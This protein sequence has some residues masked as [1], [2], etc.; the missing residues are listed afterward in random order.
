MKKSTLMIIAAIAVLGMWAISSYN[1]LVD[2]DEEVK[3][4]WADVEA[5]YQRRMDLV[6]QAVSIVKSSAKFEK[7]TLTE[8]IEARSKATSITLNVDSL[9]EESMRKFQEAQS[10]L[11]GSLSRLMAVSEA[12]PEL[13][14]MEGFLQLQSQVEGTEN[15]INEVRKK[16]NATVKPYNV[17]VRQFPGSIFAAIFGFKTKAEFQADPEAKNAPKIDMDI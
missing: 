1:G 10:Q 9:D 4:V 14:S 17:S 2:K 16:F 7:G 11:S 3:K 13:K 15:R 12:Y 8:V 6:N 5:A